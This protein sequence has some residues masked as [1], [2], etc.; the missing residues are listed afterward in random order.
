[1]NQSC[2]YLGVKQAAVESGLSIAWWRMKI[3]MRQVPFYKVGGKILIS[4]KD[5]EN[6]MAQSRVE[7]K[8]R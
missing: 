5:L 6:L 7:P 4:R 2:E 8:R 3:F 1:M